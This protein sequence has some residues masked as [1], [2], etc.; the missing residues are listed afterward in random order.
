MYILCYVYHIKFNLFWGN[1]YTYLGEKTL[2]MVLTEFY[3]DQHI[4]VMT[5]PFKM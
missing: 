1:F 3:S 5:T 4:N 2:N